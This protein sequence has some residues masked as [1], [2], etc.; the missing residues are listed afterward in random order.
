MD[1]KLRTNQESS[2]TSNVLGSSQAWNNAASQHTPNENT[3]A[4]MSPQLP[5][6]PSNY[7]APIYQSPHSYGSSPSGA[8][9]T[10][11]GYSN[12]YGTQQYINNLP[13]NSSSPYISPDNWNQPYPPYSSTPANRSPGNFP[14]PLSR[15]H[16]HVNYSQPIP[17]SSSPSVNIH[18]NNSVYVGDAPSSFQDQS[19]SRVQV[20][21]NT[22]R[23][24]SR[25]SSNHI[26][27][28]SNRRINL[29]SGVSVSS[30]L[31]VS[32]RSSTPGQNRVAQQ[33]R[34]GGESRYNS[35]PSV[36][37]FSSPRIQ[38]LPTDT[39][40]HSEPLVG[41]QI[42][43]LPS[44]PY[45]SQADRVAKGTTNNSTK[46][47]A[48]AKPRDRKFR[49]SMTDVEDTIGG[50]CDGRKPKI[51]SSVLGQKS[52]IQ[53]KKAAIHLTNKNAKN[54]KLTIDDGKANEV[55]EG[56]TS[57]T[58]VGQKLNNYSFTKPSAPVGTKRVVIE[59]SDDESEDGYV[60]PISLS[61][62]P[63]SSIIVIDSDDEDS[64]S[65]EAVNEVKDT[66]AVDTSLI[67]SPVPTKSRFEL[68]LASDS[69]AD[70]SFS[71]SKQEAPKPLSFQESK[72]PSKVDSF[73]LP[74]KPA[75]IHWLSSDEEDD[76]TFTAMPVERTTSSNITRRHDS[77]PLEPVQTESRQPS[78]RVIKN[79][80]IERS[81]ENGASKLKSST[82]Q[83]SG[84]QT[85]DTAT[86]SKSTSDA[87]FARPTT[88]CSLKPVKR[89]STIQDDNPGA[90][91]ARRSKADSLL[92]ELPKIDNF[93]YSYKELQEVNRVSRK[94]E[95][96][97]AEMELYVC[98][99]LHDS[100][101]DYSEDIKS[102]IVPFDSEVPLIY[103]KRNVKAEYIKEKDY[104]I[105]ISAKKVAQRTFVLYYLAQDF[106]TKLHSQ[107]L[108]RDVT[109]ATEQMCNILV[110]KYHVIIMVE[111]YDQLINK[112]QTY[113]Q[114]QFRSQVLNGE[115]QAKRKKDDEQMSK[116][117]E[118]AEIERLSNRAQ[119][120]LK[121]NIFTV[122]SR[123]EGVMWLNS[124]TYTI[125][126][127][128]YDKY[129]RNKNLANLG[130]VRSGSDTKATFLQSFQH[131]PLMTHSKAQIL[132]SS[133]ASMYSIYSKL[134]TS[135][136]LGKDAT[137]KN[138]VPPSVDSTLLNFFTSDDPDKAIT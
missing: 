132:Q 76:D 94:K 112:I 84:S 64:V 93:E 53:E 3:N 4:S 28:S 131:I 65:V 15:P 31:F 6:A 85:L 61:A 67:S 62:A 22:P 127:A 44:S 37:S 17:P 77:V 83:P 66:N 73:V 121:V 40:S 87:G 52:A 1:E 8:P 81:T 104:F 2:N 14:P 34:S 113:K 68:N 75:F 47:H 12:I 89:A 74:E 102:K 26:Q 108:K 95:E 90:K 116:F 88:E 48:T 19:S 43:R 25:P 138:I 63:E 105:P 111:G 7:S 114:R 82:F 9:P 32:S 103:W 16:P 30:Q 78:T 123:P 36:P 33:P 56:Q 41:N 125:G 54:K 71:F 106:L 92:D 129:E 20:Q 86:R 109:S 49:M 118:P 45:S 97:Y 27:V 23:G 35:S 99:K 136:T 134:C 46:S 42:D 79:S 11:N 13:N 107:E 38:E 98:S 130:A 18:I 57:K 133:H 55:V 110:Q 117:P 135:G 100:I 58:T 137:G 21:N 60:R 124:F 119:L 91:K 5:L 51:R 120:D 72:K 128:L 69:I 70:S 50:W 126:S 59:L 10:S 101:K 24:P 96:L 122:R 115:E 29:S 39:P 80:R